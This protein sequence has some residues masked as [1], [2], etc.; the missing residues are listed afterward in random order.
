VAEEKITRKLTT[1]LAADVEGYTR[2]MRADEEA[3]L[4][5]L[6]EYR[7]V[8]DG[9]IARHEGR[10]FSTGGDSVLAE[11]GSVVEAVRC[12][13]SCQEEISSR[14]AE[15]ADDR[16]LIFRIGINVG[17][18]MIRDGDLFGDGVNV[19]ARLEG[20]AEPGGVCISGSVFEQ[21]KHKLSL[22]FEDIG[23]QEVKNIAE[24]VSAY[25]LVP[26][27]VEASGTVAPTDAG[28]PLPLAD[29]PSVAILPFDNMSSDP[30]QVFFAEGIAEDIITE[31]SKFHSL[32]VI[33]RNSSFAFK[34]QALE[35]KEIGRRL[36]VRYVVEGSV[37]RAGN[38][39]RITAQL[40]DAVE[41]THLWAE[42]YDRDL[43]DIFAVQ[44]EVTHAI[45]TTIEPHLADTERLRARRKPPDSLDAWASYQ[46][47]LWHL[48]Q[49]TAKDN[50]QGIA[51]ME[52]AVVLDPDFAPAH[53][54]LAFALYYH[55]ML[56]FSD[57]REAYLNRAQ[58]E[59]KRAVMLDASDPYAHVALSRSYTIRGEHDTAIQHCDR[60]ISL[61][62][63]YSVAHFCR[64][65]S[66]WMSGRAE[67]ALPSNA[68]AMR[69][70]PHDPIMWGVMASRSIA[71]TLLGRYEEGLDW[72]RRAL[73]QP[74]AELIASVAEL[75][76]LGHL[77]RTGEAEVALARA[78][79]FKPDVTT[80]FVDLVL[81][82]TDPDCHMLFVDG[83]RKAG[84]PD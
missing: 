79:K 45:V 26:G 33:S 72:A 25:R 24:P 12:A 49:Y 61:N 52:R 71:L 56:G 42:R 69:L 41:D 9:L 68:E 21:I 1:I 82:I 64:G 77:G 74:N 27:Q 59:G 47:G 22:G 67:E 65:H 17:D 11:F 48:Y 73:Q 55:V 4:K 30:E 14:N 66:L 15:L 40:I 37:R 54:G 51:F 2:L 20:L 8:I 70:S 3:T 53:A 63:S 28:E 36:G 19:A 76:A 50:A 39:V 62:P 44:D 58:E 75:C 80:G 29:K 81:P 83:L 38:R 23:P 16:K 46:R 10:V 34:G 35:V 57:D 13:I 31:L 84:M 7:D 78:R 32:F 43:E 18:V 6:G 5:T 60:A